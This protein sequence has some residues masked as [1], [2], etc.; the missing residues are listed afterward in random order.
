MTMAK[1]MAARVET[2]TAPFQCAL[3]TKAGL[4]K[5]GP[6]LSES[7]RSRR[8]CNDRVHRWS[9][10]RTT[11]SL[12]T[13]CWKVLPESQKVTG[14]CRSCDTSTGPLQL[15]CEMIRA[16]ETHLIPQGEGGGNKGTPSCRCSSVLGMHPALMAAQERLRLGQR[17]FAFLDDVCIVCLPE[18]VETVVS[19]LAAELWAHA[20]IQVHEG[21]TQVW[22]RAGEEPAGMHELTI[23]ARRIDP[24][25]VVCERRYGS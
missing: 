20:H 24:D 4:R 23:R 12:A 25:A 10:W 5:C 17:I 1:Q 8:A 14:C 16:G 18:R 6:H 22:N 21:K 15:S 19:I 11:S 9:G 3:T 2:A 13:P 7:D